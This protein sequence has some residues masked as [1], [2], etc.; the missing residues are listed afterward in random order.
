MLWTIIKEG[1][2]TASLADGSYTAKVLPELFLKYTSD[3]IRQVILQW[4]GPEVKVPGA[5]EWER[6]SKQKVEKIEV[7]VGG[8]TLALFHAK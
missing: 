2:E 8:L 3:L 7:R 6:Q 1:K 5:S 4:L